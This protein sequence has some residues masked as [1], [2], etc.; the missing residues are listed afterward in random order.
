[1]S[2]TYHATMGDRGRLVVPAELR[3]RAGFCEGRAVVLIET[4]R[5]VVLVT[6]DRLKELVREDLA[7]LD[8]VGALLADR[9]RDAAASR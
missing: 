7:G 5:G 1:M 3:E 2:G 9:R 8:L 6:R 4:P